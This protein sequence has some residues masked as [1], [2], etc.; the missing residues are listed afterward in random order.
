MPLEHVSTWNS[1]EWIRITAEEA[2][3]QYSNGRTVS[4]DEKVFMCDLCHEYVLFTT[5]QKN[6]RHFKHSS[7]AQNKECEA[8]TLAIAS[9]GQDFLRKSATPPM[10]INVEHGFIGL[11]IGFPPMPA[12][13]LAQAESMQLQA[14]VLAK[15]KPVLTKDVD[16]HNFSS[17][18]IAYYSIGPCFFEEYRFALSR[19]DARNTFP[20]LNRTFAGL[21]ASGTVFEYQSRRK[22]PFDGDVEIGKEYYLLTK[23]S[24]Y[25]RADLIV[26]RLRI[27]GDHQLYSVIASQITKD[28]TAFFFQYH[29][30]LTS[31]PAKLTLIWPIISEQEEAIQTDKEKLTFLLMG[32]ASLKT[33][34]QGINALLKR[35]VLSEKPSTQLICVSNTS[36]LRMLWVARLSVLRCL[37]IWHRPQDMPPALSSA[38]EA[39]VQTENMSPFISGKY[40]A[41]PKGNRL[42][43]TLAYDGCM[44]RRRKHVVTEI[45]KIKASVQR[46]TERLGFD[47]SISIYHGLD[48]IATFS[49]ER[50]DRHDIMQEQVLMASLRSCRGM[51]V[52]FPRRYAWVLARF[53]ARSRARSYLA[54]AM[55]R[56]CI[57]K[58]ALHLIQR[59]V[60]GM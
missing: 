14:M 15:G 42:F 26:T 46:N 32:D 39:I 47:E 43:V 59:Y 20:M 1:H 56:G 37:N 49:F 48:N 53:D 60:R 24:E 41:L 55:R 2:D 7:S 10:R 28:T 58:D 31:T 27:V 25:S 35:H 29:C 45:V 54:S 5:K 50:P 11:E 19:E 3:K 13:L 30:R 21:N 33:E 40:P 18:S 44:I 38:E 36:H 23:A 17:E 57:H 16:A 51:A 6:K 4:A 12:D 8:R 52:P 34:P 9:Q 22:V